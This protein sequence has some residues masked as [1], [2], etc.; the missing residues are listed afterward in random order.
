MNE[1]QK[2]NTWDLYDPE[3]KQKFETHNAA[4]N[5]LVNQPYDDNNAEKQQRMDDHKNGYQDAF[6]S[7]FKN[8]SE[9]ADYIIEPLER[10]A[11]ER[12]LFWVAIDTKSLKTLDD[13]NTLYA[14]TQ[15]FIDDQIKEASGGMTVDK[16]TTI[17][18]KENTR[19]FYTAF[20][21]NG[22]RTDTLISIEEKKNILN[23][24][25]T[26]LEENNGA[27]VVN[28]FEEIATQ[29][30]HRQLKQTFGNTHK[31]NWYNHI[32]AV[33]FGRESF[34][35][36]PMTFSN[37]NFHGASFRS[38]EKIPQAIKI[39]RFNAAQD[40]IVDIP[41]GELPALGSE[42]NEPNSLW[43]KTKKYLGFGPK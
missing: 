16:N 39:A 19:S 12:N 38:L 11:K 15:K 40:E 25:F 1:L 8:A 27:S 10:R 14:D 4:F 29:L 23:I 36:V 20:P 9:Y 41:H 31:I 34:Q 13:V 37:N 22:Y 5:E 17:F 42:K 2:S 43:Y 7:Q 18:Q 28:F 35:H 6:I 3:W 32:P 21:V 24:C 33:H 26:N 30:Y